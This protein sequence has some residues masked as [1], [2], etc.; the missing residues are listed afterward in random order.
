MDIKA[1]LKDFLI[2]RQQAY[3]QTFTGVFAERVLADLAKFCKANDTAFHPDARVHAVL[4][5]RRE[6]WLRLQKQLNLTQ[7]QLLKLYKIEGE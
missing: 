6:V 7:D 3:Q 1:K 4:E 2:T 5:G